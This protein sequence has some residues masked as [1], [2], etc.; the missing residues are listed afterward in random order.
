MAHDE[1]NF[2]D[3]SALALQS[4]KLVFVES[5]RNKNRK[6]GLPEEYCPLFINVDNY[7]KILKECSPEAPV[8]FFEKLLNF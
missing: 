2:W 4:Q 8:F 3:C 1:T 5:D 6:E 7:M